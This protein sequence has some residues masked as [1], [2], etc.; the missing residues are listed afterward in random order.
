L[1]DFQRDLFHFLAGFDHIGASCEDVPLCCCGN[2]P[3]T[4]PCYIYRKNLPGDWMA[5]R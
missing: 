3:V 2:F 5:C 4:L 1:Q